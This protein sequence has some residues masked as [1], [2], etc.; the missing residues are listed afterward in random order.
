MDNETS[1]LPQ[2]SAYKRFVTE[3][4]LPNDIPQMDRKDIHARA[5][6]Q[7]MPS[8]RILCAPKDVSE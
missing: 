4:A 6:Q 7:M 8:K 2:I 3:Q 1:L 5:P